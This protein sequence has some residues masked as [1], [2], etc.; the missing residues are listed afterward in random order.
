MSSTN[1]CAGVAW[2]NKVRQSDFR[3]YRWMLLTIPKMLACLTTF[4]LS[5]QVSKQTIAEVKGKWWYIHKNISHL[6]LVIILIWNF[7]SVPNRIYYE[8]IVLT[9]HAN[10]MQSNMKVRIWFLLCNCLSIIIILKACILMKSIREER[11]QVSDFEHLHS[12][13]ISIYT[14]SNFFYFV[15]N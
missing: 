14:L 5:F 7:L 9:M 4:M 6:S 15:C 11:K 1:F 10:D 3:N 8:Y 12:K 13:M 2:K